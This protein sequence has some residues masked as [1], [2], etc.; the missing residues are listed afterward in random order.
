MQNKEYIITY[1]SV[2]EARVFAES[3]EEAIESINGE[4]IAGKILYNQNHK[5]K[6]II[7]GE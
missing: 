5:M 7:K 1:E 4:Y 3:I 6:E 2:C